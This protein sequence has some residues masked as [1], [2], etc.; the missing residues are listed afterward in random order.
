MNAS[1]HSEQGQDL[2]GTSDSFQNTFFKSNKR[3]GASSAYGGSQY[4]STNVS[5]NFNTTNIRQRN[6]LSRFRTEAIKNMAVKQQEN[7]NHKMPNRPN[8]GPLGANLRYKPNNYANPMLNVNIQ[9]KY[10][11]KG[12]SAVN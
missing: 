7:L 3:G 1:T 9:A 5:F 4:T 8:A 12:I 11:R 2:L 10:V 6:Y